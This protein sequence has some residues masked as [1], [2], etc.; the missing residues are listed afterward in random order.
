MY[1]IYKQFYNLVN[2]VNVANNFNFKHILI[3]SI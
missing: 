1:I 2:I 3:I